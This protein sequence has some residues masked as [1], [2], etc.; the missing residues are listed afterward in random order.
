M[1]VSISEAALILGVSASTLPRWERESLFH[2]DL[3][4]PGV[5]VS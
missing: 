2:A 4:A 5:F 3:R 1:F